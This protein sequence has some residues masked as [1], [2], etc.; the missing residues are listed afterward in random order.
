MSIT[1]QT[2]CAVSDCG[3]A[4]DDCECWAYDWDVWTYEN[5]DTSTRW[6]VHAV[7][8]HGSFRLVYEVGCYEQSI[9]VEDADELPRAA[10]AMRAATA[11]LEAVLGEER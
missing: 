10:R 4:P 6:D 9:D 5:C 3:C 2:L 1:K 11:A 8:N 7:G